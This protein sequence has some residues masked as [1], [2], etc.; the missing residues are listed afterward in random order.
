M[1]IGLLECMELQ[2]LV[3]QRPVQMQCLGACSLYAFIVVQVCGYLWSLWP[4]S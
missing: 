2:R 1:H 4:V 3:K